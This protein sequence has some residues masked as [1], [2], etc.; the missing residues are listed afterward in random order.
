MSL[1][2]GSVL[3][4]NEITL[5]LPTMKEVAV[6]GRQQQPKGDAISLAPRQSASRELNNMG[7]NIVLSC[8]SENLDTRIVP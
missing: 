7:E 1:A 5:V 3:A 2:L 8:S 6:H 4:L